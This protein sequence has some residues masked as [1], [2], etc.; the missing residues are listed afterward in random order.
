MEILRY[1]R[2]WAVYDG[3]QLVCVCV[4]KQGATEVVRRLQAIGDEEYERQFEEEQA[5]YR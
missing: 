5:G 3:E 1:G 2:H 4:Y